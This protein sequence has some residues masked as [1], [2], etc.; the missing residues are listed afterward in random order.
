MNGATDHDL[1]SAIKNKALSLGFDLVG[2]TSADAPARAPY[3]RQWIDAGKHG[4][5]HYL[6]ERVD[7][8]ADPAVYFPGA[9]SVVC[10][11]LNYHTPLEAPPDDGPRGR[12]ARYALGQD[13]HT[14][15][16]DRLYDLADWI[17]GAVPGALT[18]CGVDTVPVLERE[19][20]ARAGIG[21]VGKH[22]IVINENIGSWI[23][24]GEVLT[25]L[26]LP[27]DTPAV[28]RCGTCTRCIDA[29]P[30][31]A[32]TG[33][34]Q[35]DAR[36]CISYLSIEHEGEISEELEKAT[37][38]WIFGCDVCQDVCPY[39]T[40]G[41]PPIATDPALQP[42][43][44]SGTVGLNDVLNWTQEDYHAQTRRS[45]TRRVKLDVLQRNAGIALKNLNR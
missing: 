39:N 30:T 15:I 19:L 40:S 38:D 36:R 31:G 27:V 28:D 23:L 21:W 2:I 26:D 12:V 37:G 22:T 35:L 25:T 9:K 32:I 1:A 33:P 29:C 11:G 4:Q 44:A 10:V 42:R 34:Y 17:R 24:L 6:A 7:E 13:Y 8:R 18:R 14:L 43:Y 16:K 41:R 5:M 20:A 45:A 3:L